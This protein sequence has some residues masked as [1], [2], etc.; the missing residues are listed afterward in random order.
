[1]GQQA[2]TRSLLNHTK[3]HALKIEMVPCR[4]STTTTP[5]PL[6]VHMSFFLPW[7]YIVFIDLGMFEITK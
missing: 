4:G 2:S 5:I 7:F 3:P 1:M 6:Q